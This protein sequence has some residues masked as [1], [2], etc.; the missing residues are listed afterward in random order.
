MA[1]N[2]PEES[3]TNL[4]E[5]YYLSPNVHKHKRKKKIQMF[6]WNGNCTKPVWCE[7]KEAEIDFANN[8]QSQGLLNKSD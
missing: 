5:N 1:E 3:R 6:M 2:K 4:D 8:E 7:I